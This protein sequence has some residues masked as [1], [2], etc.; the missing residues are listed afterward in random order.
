MGIR[1]WLGLSGFTTKV[2]TH[3]PNV[4][5]LNLDPKVLLQTQLQFISFLCVPRGPA[6]RWFIF[7]FIK[8]TGV[9]LKRDQSATRHEEAASNWPFIKKPSQVDH[10]AGISR[11]TTES[12]SINYTTDEP[13]ALPLAPAILERL[14]NAQ[15]HTHTHTPGR[16]CTCTRTHSRR[17]TEGSS[18]GN[19]TGF[20]RS[21]Q[22]TKSGF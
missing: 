7:Y 6:Y 3:T 18:L 2:L 10:S 4:T 5:T 16:A 19:V 1:V 13:H 22:I 15:M 8:V 9:P 21:H 12:H 20:N 11:V 14:G 17:V